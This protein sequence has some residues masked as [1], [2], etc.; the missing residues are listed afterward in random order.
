MAA[1]NHACRPFGNTFVSRWAMPKIV[2][3]DARRAEIAEAVMRVIA[4][5][6]IEGASVRTIAAES[7]WSAGAV[8]HYFSSQDELLGFAADFV[9]RRIEGRL[10]AAIDDGARPGRA[11]VTH[12]LEQLLPLDG[13]RIAESRVWLAL[14]VRCSRDPGLDE[15]RLRGWDG[16]RELCR[17]AVC[18]LRGLPWP[19][20]IGD[21]D[22]DGGA[23]AGAAPDAV[24]AADLHAFLDGLTL[25]AALVPERLTARAAR[26]ALAAYLDRL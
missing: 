15:L 12:L 3:R 20:S 24:A 22:P 11:R 2:D 1:V 4:R 13:E 21:A 19:A 5:D 8:R 10:Q 17:M 25:Q 23:D 18:E 6:G 14:L 26:L 16:Q 7:G 9:M